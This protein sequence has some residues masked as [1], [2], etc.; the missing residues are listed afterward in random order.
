MYSWK[1]RSVVGSC[2]WLLRNL[3]RAICVVTGLSTRPDAAYHR[4]WS[5]FNVEELNHCHYRLTFANCH[6]GASEVIS[7]SE[8][9]LELPNDN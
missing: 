2:R 9:S 1:E 7:E 3:L 5:M 8:A 4:L 6:F